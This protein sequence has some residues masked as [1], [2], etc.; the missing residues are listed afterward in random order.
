[1]N[2]K[3][4]ATFESTIRS[5]V[6]S[7]NDYPQPNVLMAQQRLLDAIYWLHVEGDK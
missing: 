4:L 2:K 3:T 6:Q 1:M 7:L 5:V